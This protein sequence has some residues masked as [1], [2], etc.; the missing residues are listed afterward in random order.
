MT[1][2]TSV[3][4]TGVKKANYRYS[5]SNFFTSLKRLVK[6]KG[7]IGSLSSDS[8]SRIGIFSEGNP[9]IILISF[10]FMTC[11]AHS[12]VMLYLSDEF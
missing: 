3:K 1:K 2:I 10:S 5:L 7:L 9:A 8:Y 11:L 4:T 6:T 12:H